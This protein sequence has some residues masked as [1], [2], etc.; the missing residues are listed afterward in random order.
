MLAFIATEA[1]LPEP[2]IQEEQEGL[3]ITFL[4][5]IFTEDYLRKLEV[6]ERQIRAI[7][8]V[9]EKGQIT[10]SDYQKINEIG[11]S[12]AATELQNLVD[13]RL[14][15]RIGSTGRGTKYMLAKPTKLN[16]R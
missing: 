14:L 5:D 11:K 1:G 9:K 16:I 2:V 15:I 12:V 3:G 4:K 8:H 10:N 13:K 7:L 6:N